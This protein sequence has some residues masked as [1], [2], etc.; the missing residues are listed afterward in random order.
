MTCTPA[1]NA[2]ILLHVL[3]SIEIIEEYIHDMEREEFMENLQ[4]QDAVLRKFPPLG[5]ETS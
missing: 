5:L 2:T 4:V 1:A 3:E